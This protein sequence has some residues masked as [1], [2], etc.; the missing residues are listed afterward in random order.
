MKFSHRPVLLQE[1]L[2]N[3]QIKPGKKYIDMTLGGGGH[4]KAILEMGGL[5]LGLDT[6]KDA[7]AHTKSELLE[8]PKY[9]GRI[10]IV[11][12]NFR[13]FEEIAQ[14]HGFDTVDG[15]LFDLGVSSY[16]LD[17]PTRGFSFKDNAP[18]DMRMDT[19]LGVTAADLLQ[20][21][22]QEQLYSLFKTYGQEPHARAISK[23]II[24]LRKQKPIQTTKELTQ[25]IE[26]IYQHTYIKTH[27]AT[28][29]FQ[30][31]RIAV[32]DELHTFE[33]TLPKTITLLKSKGRIVVISFHSLEDRIAKN[34]FREFEKLNLGKICTQKPI[35]PNDEE[36]KS[37]RK[38]R[39]AKMRV[40]ERN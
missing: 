33:Q 10:Y 5:V 28:R 4:S 22:S 18:L 8:N 31:L 32:N 13:N 7:I 21:L 2:E 1:T 40:F 11:K 3:L 26:Q 12:S 29:V 23:A 24:E 30:A 25:V 19:D 9:K 6:D 35:V 39:S 16:Q 15:I 38:S 20:V 37:N 17:I 14:A 27:P 36:I 34:V